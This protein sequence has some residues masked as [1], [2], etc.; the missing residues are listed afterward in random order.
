M[1]DPI[2]ESKGAALRRDFDRLTIRWCVLVVGFV[3]EGLVLTIG[4]ESPAASA[5]DHWWVR[6]A[7]I[8]PHLIRIGAASVAAF[9]VLLV[10]R[11]RATLEYARQSAADHRWQPWLLLHL[12]AFAALYAFLANATRGAGQVS[13]AGLALCEGLA[14][15]TIAFWFF[16]LAPLDYWRV[17]VVRERLALLAAITAA[18]A[19]W[20]G[21]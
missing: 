21:G 13:D 5:G 18:T 4:F 14:V 15:A 16:A 9:V 6:L 3:A 8:A 7:A 12:L 20:L 1:A 19:A 10:P 2:G 11:F 17:F